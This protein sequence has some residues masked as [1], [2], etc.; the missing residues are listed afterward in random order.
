MNALADGYL[1][2]LALFQALVMFMF[3]LGSVGPGLRKLSPDERPFVLAAM[4]GF[5]V[6][7]LLN[8]VAAVGILFGVGWVRI[9][10]CV[11][12]VMFAVFQMWVIATVRIPP[13]WSLLSVIA[14]SLLGA[15]LAIAA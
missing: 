1:I 11:V 9:L 13:Y 8:L 12:N 2:A 14:A 6:M 15:V 3:A 5:G 10:A 7:T 4:S